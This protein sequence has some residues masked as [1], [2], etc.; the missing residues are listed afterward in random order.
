MSIEV[1]YHWLSRNPYAFKEYAGMYVAIVGREVVG[2]GGTAE[3]AYKKAFE[4]CEGRFP[5][6]GY[7]RK[8]DGGLHLLTGQAGG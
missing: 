4:K 8:G 1:D 7:V 2:V 5:A 3:E 6:I